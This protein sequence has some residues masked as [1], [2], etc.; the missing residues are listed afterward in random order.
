MFTLEKPRNDE[1]HPDYI[2]LVFL[3]KKTNQLA[4][5]RKTD[6]YNSVKRCTSLSL[7]NCSKIAMLTNIS[8]QASDVKLEPLFIGP[9]SI[10]GPDPVD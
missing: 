10:V 5:S 3:T 2:P 9:K 1:S 7:A 4:N 8:D 6:R